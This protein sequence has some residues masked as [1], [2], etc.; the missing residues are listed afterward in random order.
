VMLE[1]GP[2][3]R[4]ILR[5]LGPDCSKDRLHAVYLELCDCLETGK[6]FVD[7]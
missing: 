4:R 3:A 1:Q 6:M 2:L 7:R 5:A